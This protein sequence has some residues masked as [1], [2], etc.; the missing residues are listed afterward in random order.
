M[1]MRHGK[2]DWSTGLADFDRPL[3][4][5]GHRDAP[6]V[7]QW[8]ETAGHAPDR[9]VTSAAMRAKTTVEYVVDHF[10]IPTNAV[11]ERRD[12]YLAGAQ[13]WLDVLAE[14]TRP[15]ADDLLICGHNPGLDDLVEHLAG[16]VPIRTADG[17]LMTTAAVALFAVDDWSALTPETVEFEEIIRPRDLA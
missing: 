10:S 16:R 9:V 15:S 3:S 4:G 17:K 5:R 2:S 13:T 12:L 8:L 11:D 6:K 7:A 1:V 14:R